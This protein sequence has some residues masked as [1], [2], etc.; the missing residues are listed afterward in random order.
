MRS[1]IRP[2]GTFP[3]YALPDHTNTV[4]TLSELQGRDPLIVLLARGHYCPKEHQQH[5]ELAANQSDRD[6]RGRS[7]GPRP[8]LGIP[9]GCGGRRWR[10]SRSGYRPPPPCRRTE[11]C[12]RQAVTTSSGHRGRTRRCSVTGAAADVG[13]SV[14][15]N[16]RFTPLAARPH[17]LHG[18]TTVRDLSGRRWAR[19]LSPLWPS[20]P[21]YPNKSVA[22]KQNSTD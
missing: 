16:R 13:G 8:K 12:A 3:D 6:R 20:P 15:P 9:A 17:R 14:T 5:L 10:W 22:S 21:S 19:R 4:R 2:G 7:I 18:T 1:D 11:C